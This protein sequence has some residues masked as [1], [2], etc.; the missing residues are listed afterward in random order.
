[1]LLFSCGSW[2]SRPRG[3]EREGRSLRHPCGDVRHAW[4]VGLQLC[5]ST[6]GHARA[7]GWW[8]GSEEVALPSKSG[9]AALRR[10]RPCRQT[11]NGPVLQ[12]LGPGKCWRSLAPELRSEER[13]RRRDA[14]I[15]EA[16]TEN[17]HAPP[18]HPTTQEK[19]CMATALS[20][21]ACPTRWTHCCRR[22]GATSGDNKAARRVE[23]RAPPRCSNGCRRA[24]GRKRA[25]TAS[26][27][28]A[29]YSPHQEPGWSKC[30]QGPS[31]QAHGN[32][33]RR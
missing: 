12:A 10:S 2:I 7:E 30:Q 29:E 25:G 14:R 8:C 22:G 33:R 26:L 20:I 1:M 9:R 16:R 4:L 28:I 17:I 15:P 32:M 23:H 21:F 5:S 11:T 31:V 19:Q 24:C 18:S 27:A 13:V 3:D 6:M